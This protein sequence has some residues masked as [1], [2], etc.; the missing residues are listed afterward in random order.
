[1]HYHQYGRRPAAYQPI[2]NAAL[3]HFDADAIL[4]ASRERDLTVE[5]RETLDGCKLLRDM[6]HDLDATLDTMKSFAAYEEYLINVAVP[7]MY[8]SFEELDEESAGMLQLF[9]RVHGMAVRMAVA[10]WTRDVMLAGW[11]R[12][13]SISTDDAEVVDDISRTKDT[14]QEKAIA[15]VW[16]SFG[17][18]DFAGGYDVPEDVTLQDFALKHLLKGDAVGGVVVGCSRPEHVLEALRTADLSCDDGEQ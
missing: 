7:L 9:F 8:G 2:L 11:K 4:E 18:G 14:K 6:I 17:F 16:E 5:E 3:S 12:V 15:E 10:R 1:M 13:D